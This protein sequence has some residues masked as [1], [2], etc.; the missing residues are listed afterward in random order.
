MTEGQP[1]ICDRMIKN[2]T[3]A[4]VGGSS[5]ALYLLVQGA[6][7]VRKTEFAPPVRKF[8]QRF[9]L[10]FSG[11]RCCTPQW[12]GHQI[13]RR[14]TAAGT[15]SNVTYLACGNGLQRTNG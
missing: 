14:G 11:K 2:H 9:Q 7:H 15:C 8:Q 1:H 12:M 4:N 3:G 5:I 13:F 10:I 6:R